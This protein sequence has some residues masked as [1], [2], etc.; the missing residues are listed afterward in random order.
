MAKIDDLDNLIAEFEQAAGTISQLQELANN[1]NTLKSKLE[2]MLSD[3][4]AKIASLHEAVTTYRN[5]ISDTE[6]LKDGLRQKIGEAQT[7]VSNSSKALIELKNE[8]RS[9]LDKVTSEATHIN[10]ITDQFIAKFSELENN[11]AS[12]VANVI[13]DLSS[14]NKQLHQSLSSHVNQSIAS[15]P[16]EFSKHKNDLEK[17]IN[18]AVQGFLLEQEAL[19]SGLKQKL[20]SDLN[21][22]I[23]ELQKH[24]DNQRNM[25][26]F[27]LKEA[28][29][30]IEKLESTIEKRTGIWGLFK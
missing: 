23:N 22:R 19:V 30:R 27:K 16:G 13:D 10:N 8:A 14:K 17:S 18:I 7:F 5:E 2:V 3:S 15:L 21:Q 6:N 26:K 12:K 4:Q 28:I 29:S 24:T 25:E 11:I 1:A 9:T 20:E